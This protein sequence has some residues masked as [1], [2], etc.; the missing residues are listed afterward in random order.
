MNIPFYY[1]IKWG[2][3]AF[4]WNG[5][6][7]FCLSSLIRIIENCYNQLRE[8]FNYTFKEPATFHTF[9]MNCIKRGMLGAQANAVWHSFSTNSYI[10]QKC[11]CPYIY[12]A[13][14][15]SYILRTPVHIQTDGGHVCA[16]SRE[17]G[18]MKINWIE[19]GNCFKFMRNSISILSYMQRTLM[20]GVWDGRSVEEFSI[21]WSPVWRMNSIFVAFSKIYLKLLSRVSQNSFPFDIQFKIQCNSV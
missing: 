14:S 11:I 9:R 13:F 2:Y 17:W 6:L 18:T 3:T 15:I 12:C 16:T 4:K 21:F 1:N 20:P 5:N 8:N 19:I 7:K 10:A